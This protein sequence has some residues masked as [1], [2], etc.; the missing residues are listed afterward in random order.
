MIFKDLSKGVI[1]QEFVLKQNE[2][3]KIHVLTIY[4]NLKNFDYY[5]EMSKRNISKEINVAKDLTLIF[6]EKYISRQE[7]EEEKN[8]IK[9]SKLRVEGFLGDQM[10]FS[11]NPYINKSTYFM[12]ILKMNKDEIFDLI[13][14]NSEVFNEI[15]KW[16]YELSGFNLKDNPYSI[17]NVLFF[18]ATGVEVDLERVKNNPQNIKL[19]IR[20]NLNEIEKMTAV[21]TFRFHKVIVA[22]K[23]LEITEPGKYPI[24]IPASYNLWNSLDVEV[25]NQ[26][27]ELVYLYNNAHF[28]MEISLKVGITNSQKEEYVK[29]LDKNILLKDIF[30][31]NFEIADKSE[32]IKNLKLLNKYYNDERYFLKSLENNYEIIFS[33]PNEQRKI[34]EHFQRI[35]ENENFDR[36]W[37]FDPYFDLDEFKDTMKDFITLINQNLHTQK[38]IIFENK[39]KYE[40]NDLNSKIK[41]W[42]EELR[43]KYNTTI[44]FV[45][46]NKHFHD[47]FIFLTI[48]KN[49][50]E[51]VKSG[52]LLGSSINSIGKNFSTIVELSVPKSQE[53][54]KI[55]YNEIYVKSIAEQNEV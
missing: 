18:E 13:P 52:F 3:D 41:K 50:E 48:N 34:F 24:K 44:D 40:Q 2:D 7:I 29:T 4:H 37:I 54:F 55:L 15:C 43:Q 8:S 20:Y 45:C 25:Y 1:K 28:I 38:I 22:T 23:K 35:F 9:V 31:E 42:K 21:L 16:V 11:K 12:E 39:K 47:R 26:N 14:E 27:D 19:S 51:I 6:T 49:G 46:S 32:Y 33:T 10:T 53:I 17:G 5:Q 30:Y 36:I